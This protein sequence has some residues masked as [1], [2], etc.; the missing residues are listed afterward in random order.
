[1]ILYQKGVI[2]KRVVISLA[3]AIIGISLMSGCAPKKGVK[4]DVKKVS[5]PKTTI[6]K[7][8]AVPCNVPTPCSM[9]KP[10]NCCK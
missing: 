2:M 5:K 3:V 9:P 1:V 10:C 7:P 8:V 4:K 6:A